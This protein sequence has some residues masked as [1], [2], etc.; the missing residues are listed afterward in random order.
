MICSDSK[1]MLTNIENEKDYNKNHL[2][3]LVQYS[4]VSS[5]TF[6]KNVG[7][8]IKPTYSKNDTLIKL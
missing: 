1:K 8:I 7:E 3:K 4:E 6:T 5:N 2:S